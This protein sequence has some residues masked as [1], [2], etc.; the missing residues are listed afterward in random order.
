MSYAHISWCDLQLKKKEKRKGYLEG[1]FSWLEGSCFKIDLTEMIAW[2]NTAFSSSIWYE[3]PTIGS[4]HQF[5]FV[6][7]HW[8]TLQY[9]IENPKANALTRKYK[10]QKS[11]QAGTSQKWKSFCNEPNHSNCVCDKP[12]IGISNVILLAHK[13]SFV[14]LDGLHLCTDDKF[15]Q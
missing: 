11:F 8:I 3:L 6:N 5:F 4:A 10:G 12:P 7:H 15:K 2:T 14:M 9:D 1:T 13:K